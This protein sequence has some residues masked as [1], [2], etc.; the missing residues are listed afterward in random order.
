M[1]GGRGKVLSSYVGDSIVCL[2]LFYFTLHSGSQQLQRA[3]RDYR[4][5]SE[6]CVCV[7]VCASHELVSRVESRHVNGVSPE[8]HIWPVLGCVLV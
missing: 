6:W 8:L 3:T 7:C 1:G 5:V 4:P 2:S